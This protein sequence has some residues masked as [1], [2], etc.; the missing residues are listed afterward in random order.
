MFTNR[1][2]AW[3]NMTKKIK[4]LV[5]EDDDAQ[6]KLYKDAIDDFNSTNETHSFNSNRCTSVEKSIKLLQDSSFDA[7]I[8]DLKLSNTDL[9]GQG[10][11]IIKEIRKFHRIPVFV[12]SAIP[13]ILNPDFESEKSPLFK[14]YNRTDKKNEDLLKEILSI[15]NMGITNIL[16]KRGILEKKFD[17]IFWKHISYVIDEWPIIEP[18]ISEKKLLRYISSYLLDYLQI[19]DEGNFDSFLPQEVYLIPS[20]STR[21]HTGDILLKDEEYYIIL[22]P[23]C[24]MVTGKAKNI[25]ISKIELFDGMEYYKEQLRHL[26]GTDDN[27]KEK[28]EKIFEGLLTNH[29]S[30]KYHFLPKTKQF[31]GGFIN[32]QKLKTF[33]KSDIDNYERFGKISDFFLKD[34]ISRFSNY[35]SRQG[36]PNFNIDSIKKE[37]IEND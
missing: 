5:V 29:N 12:M 37:Y 34:I 1:I 24:D 25:L 19:D 17:E 28:A 23:A 26:K 35:Y 16:G 20:P 8:I 14:V 11:I 15:Y 30:L 31:G 4:L 7:A 3:T 36:Q 18:K 6:F 22:S 9:E 21:C 33:K 27:K 32:F 2:T 13:Q 10:N